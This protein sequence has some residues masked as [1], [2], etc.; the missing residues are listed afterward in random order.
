MQLKEFKE[1]ALD[2]LSCPGDQGI[3]LLLA[4]V[5]ILKARTTTKFCVYFSHW[6]KMFFK[7]IHEIV[8]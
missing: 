1:N 7:T 6:Q 3:L 8:D 4:N 5:A 2:Y